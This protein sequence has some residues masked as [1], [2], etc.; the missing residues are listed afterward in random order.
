MVGNKEPQED[1]ARPE[2]LAVGGGVGGGPPQTPPQPRGEAQPAQ[3]PLPRGMKWRRVP[4]GRGEQRLVGNLPYARGSGTPWPGLERSK[5]GGGLRGGPWGGRQ[6]WR[7]T[8]R[9]AVG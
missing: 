1:V 7:G 5:R 4:K 8:A 3:G 6:W 9:G 2:A